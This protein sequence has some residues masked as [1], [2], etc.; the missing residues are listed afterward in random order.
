MIK[1]TVIGLMSL[2]LLM[3]GTAG[4][5]LAQTTSPSPSATP[6]PTPSVMVPSGAPATGMAQ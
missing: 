1:A 3:M 4:V 2:A 6:S 5:A